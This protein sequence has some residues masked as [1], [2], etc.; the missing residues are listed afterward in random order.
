MERSPGQLRI[1]VPEP[2][3]AQRIQ[4]RLESLESLCEQFF[5]RATKVV[6]ETAEISPSQATSSGELSVDELKDLRQRALNH[7]AVNLAVEILDGEIVEIR[8]VAVRT[9]GAPQ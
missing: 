7:P 4:D 6:I 5:G 9:S 2:F 8:P 3:A 1:R